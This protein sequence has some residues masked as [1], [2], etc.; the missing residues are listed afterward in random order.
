[1]G[2]L[3]PFKPQNDETSDIVIDFEQVKLRRALAVAA[4]Y[5]AM[6]RHPSQHDVTSQP[7]EVTTVQIDDA[8]LA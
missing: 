2:E 8:P 7:P 4:L 5:D 6:R 1:M 3:I